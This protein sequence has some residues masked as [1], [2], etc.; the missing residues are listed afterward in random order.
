VA[1]G[2]STKTAPA[3]LTSMSVMAIRRRA[4]WP[5]TA[6]A[7]EVVNPVPVKAER[8]SNRGVLQHHPGHGQRDRGDTGIELPQR[9][10]DD[11]QDNGGHAAALPHQARP[12]SQRS[13]GRP[14]T[15]QTS[16]DTAARA[17]RQVAICSAQSP[18]G[19]APA[20]DDQPRRMSP[21]HLLA[22]ALS[23]IAVAMT[24]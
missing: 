21:R 10:D 4:G 23:D 1:A 2:R 20:P 12:H 5:T 9:D 24:G 19:V 6:S 15:G 7:S 16:M 22:G 18:R 13:P 3:P 17:R 8:A 14:R 11:Q